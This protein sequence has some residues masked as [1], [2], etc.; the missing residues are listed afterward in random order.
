MTEQLTP[1]DLTVEVISSFLPEHSSDSEGR[2]AFSY[3]IAITNLGLCP[4]HLVSRRWMI[5]DGTGSEKLETGG[6][7]EGLWILPGE[8]LAWTKGAMLLSPVATL[9]GECQVAAEDGSKFAL[10]LPLYTLSIPRT[11]H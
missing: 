10:E 6:D 8:T 5:E 2:Y 3:T 9:F 4:A 1:Q 11:L 7:D